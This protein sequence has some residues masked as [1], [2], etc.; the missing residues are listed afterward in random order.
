MTP[1]TAMRTPALIPVWVS[2]EENRQLI[3]SVDDGLYGLLYE[4]CRGMESVVSFPDDDR[5][6]A[7]RPV[8]A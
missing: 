5:I 4:R 7:V 1:P 3:K 8:A 6:E 2:F